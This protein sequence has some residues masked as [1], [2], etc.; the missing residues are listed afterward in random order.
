M[1]RIE[2]IVKYN[3]YNM[4]IVEKTLARMKKEDSTVKDVEKE[5]KECKGLVSYI[6]YEINVLK[7]CFNKYRKKRLVVE[8][9]GVIAG[10][11]SS[12]NRRSSGVV[13]KSMTLVNK[14]NY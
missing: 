10:K 2:L 12:K 6:G 7:K 4:N 13:I 8:D 11:H 5:N 3:K 14:V 1:S 9:S